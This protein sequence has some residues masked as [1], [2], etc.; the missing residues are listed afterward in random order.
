MTRVSS[1][2]SAFVVPLGVDG[3]ASMLAAKTGARRRTRTPFDDALKDFWSS[4]EAQ[5]RSSTIANYRH[6][7]GQFERWAK[8]AGVHL[9]EDLSPP[10]LRAFREHLIGGGKRKVLK[11]GKRGARL[12][13]DAR[14]HPV[15]INTYLTSTKVLLNHWRALG[16]TPELSKD[17]ISDALKR[18][19]VPRE[20]AA[21]LRP[22]EFSPLLRAA[23]RH[24]RIVYAETREE[25][26]G[27]RVKGT[28]SR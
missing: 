17:A 5:L 21:F 10:R 11:G 27:L 20:E 8:K 23:L 14:R 26:A 12:D 2:G 22:A 3:L 16:L 28:T 24:D 4:C 15:T 6:G 19:P 9:T 7:I 25:H 18:L 1:P 13:T